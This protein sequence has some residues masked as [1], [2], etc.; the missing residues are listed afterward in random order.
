MGY[1]LVVPELWNKN[2]SEVIDEAEGVE[3]MILVI[4][5]R[6]ANLLK[7]INDFEATPDRLAWLSI[8][9]KAFSALDSVGG[10]LGR[11]SEYVLEILSRVVFETLLHIRTIVEPLTNG[12]GERTVESYDDAVKRLQAY[13]AWC[14]WN[15]QQYYKESLNFRNMKAAFDAKP[16][17]DIVSNPEGLSHFLNIFG[18]LDL[19]PDQNKLNSACRA[20]ERSLKIEI[21]RV[22]TWLEHPQIREWASIIRDMQLR[23]CGKSI[24]FFSLF[25][26][27]EESIRK[28]LTGFE[29]RFAY[30]LYMKGSMIIHGSSLDQS[31]HMVN[32]KVIPNFIGSDNQVDSLAQSITSRVNSIMVWL[33]ILQKQLWKI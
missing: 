16:S 27:S 10:A 28:R 13:A 6:A 8:W 4:Q 19:E 12:H 33:Y 9:T 15:D 31:L 30:T 17:A 24:T 23:A 14:F 32:N 22:K 25:S 7:G 11:N 18:P 1:Q 21:N 3:K 26:E 5:A 20:H 29:L 2:W